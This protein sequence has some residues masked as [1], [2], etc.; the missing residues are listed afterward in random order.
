MFGA[1]GGA[2]EEFA[3]AEGAIELSGDEELLA[4]AVV[5][6][7][8]ERKETFVAGG[9]GFEG[10]DGGFE[11]EAEAGADVE[12]FGREKGPH[13]K[14]RLKF[15]DLEP[16]VG[17]RKREVGDRIVKGRENFGVALTGFATAPCGFEID[18]VSAGD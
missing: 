13:E 8:E 6:I 16:I 14:P 3:E 12:G 11:G 4:A 1:D 18:A 7:V 15:S 5:G 2:G 10:E 17:G 9:G